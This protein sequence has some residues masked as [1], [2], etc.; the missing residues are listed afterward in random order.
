MSSNK[1]TKR[2]NSKKKSKEKN[3]AKNM[4]YLELIQQRLSPFFGNENKQSSSISLN[5]DKNNMKMYK[6]DLFNELLLEHM[7]TNSYD[8]L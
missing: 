4:Q 2:S 3:D 1:K 5:T 7:E 8:N 6:N